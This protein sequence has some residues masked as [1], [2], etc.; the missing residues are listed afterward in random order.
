MSN[1]KQ[2]NES[3][4]S[5]I[6]L[7]IAARI[8]LGRETQSHSNSGIIPFPEGYRAT[9]IL[10]RLTG[11]ERAKVDQWLGWKYQATVFEYLSAAGEVIQMVLRFDRADYPK[12]I[13]PLRYLGL[14]K[15]GRPQFWMSAID[16]HRPLYGLHEL[17]NR[18]DAPVLVVE[19]EKTAEAAKLL[20]PD[21][22]AI[23]WSGG[24]PGVARTEMRPLGATSPG[25]SLRLA[26]GERGGVT[27]ATAAGADCSTSPDW[28][29]AA[30]GGTVTVVAGGK[31]LSSEASLVTG[32]LSRALRARSLRLLSARFSSPRCPTTED[33]FST[34]IP[35][36]V[37]GCWSDFDGRRV[38]N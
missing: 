18:P 2:N 31:Q 8:E 3:T 20:F 13:R 14:D 4:L 32:A 27:T 11:K 22:V 26:L 19:G 33:V 7:S 23:T 35:L 30:I 5:P 10:K 21:Y 16:G 12:E 37:S 6:T 1:S 29:S 17:A 36:Q 25:R 38:E 28:A 34:M 9:N 15:L 24:A